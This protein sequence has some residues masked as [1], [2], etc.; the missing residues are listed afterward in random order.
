MDA[1]VERVTINTAILLPSLILIMYVVPHLLGVVYL[2]PFFLISFLPLI[3]RLFPKNIADLVYPLSIIS[4]LMLFLFNLLVLSHIITTNRF[5]SFLLIPLT[6][7]TGI[8]LS[9]A[10][11]IAIAIEAIFSKSL[12]KT[13]AAFSFSLLPLMDQVFVLF[14]INVYG[15]SY[16]Q[17]YMEAYTMQE[18]SL[19]ALVFSGSTNI[20]G[21]KFPPPLSVYSFPIDPVM[22][23]SMIISIVGVLSYFVVIRENKLRSQVI[24]GLSSAVF[25][26]SIMAFI[27]FYAVR[28]TSSSGLELLVAAAALVV[29]MVYASRT[30]PDRLN[31]K[32]NKAKMKDDW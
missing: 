15:Y 14:L 13:L 7:E 32:R 8:T 17:A 4:V 22:L 18:I 26:G 12:A 27:V 25:M 1:T 20:F 21:A 28:I 16:S 6:L 30:S 9:M 23:A 19:I 31:K 3:K 10:M 11:S 5:T 2:A 29:T 24:S